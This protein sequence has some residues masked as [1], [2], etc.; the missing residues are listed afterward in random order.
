MLGH[1]LENDDGKANFRMLRS[2]DDGV[3][4]EVVSREGWNETLPVGT[5][6]GAGVDT[7][8]IIRMRMESSVSGFH[9]A[10]WWKQNPIIQVYN[11]KKSSLSNTFP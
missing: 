11:K 9:G 4:F 7:F 1:L 6:T 3:S 2:E 10:I 8:E 5:T